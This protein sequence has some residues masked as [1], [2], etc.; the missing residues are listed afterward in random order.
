MELTPMHAA[1]F[2]VMASTGLFVLFFFKIYRFVKVMYAFGCSSAM[3]QVIFLPLIQGVA[4]RFQVRDKIV[5]R[6]GTA[7][8]GDITHFDIIAGFLSYLLGGVWLYMSFTLRHP[9][10]NIFYWVMQDIMGTCMCIVFLGVIKLNS[11]KVATILLISAFCYDIFMVFITPYLFKGESVM[12]TVATS[13]GPP[14]ADPS[15]C[16]K[17]PDDVNCQGER[18]KGTQI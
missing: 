12:I 2:I 18:R 3:M 8:F 1:G 14:K 13:G 11:I 17:Y 16:E 7:D 6:T 15:W 5:W 4:R 10:E 9:D